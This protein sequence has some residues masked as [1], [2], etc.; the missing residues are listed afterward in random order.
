VSV[1]QPELRWPVVLATLA[2]AGLYTALP[3][4]LTLGPDWLGHRPHPHLWIS[5]PR[6]HDLGNGVVAGRSHSGPAWKAGKSDRVAAVG[7]GSVVEQRPDLRLLVLAVGRGWSEHRGTPKD[8]YGR[9]IS[10]SADEASPEPGEALGRM[11][12]GLR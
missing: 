2:T 1:A 12:A 3:E 7:G 4:R 6:Q 5:F 10:V 11:A 8:T 9:R